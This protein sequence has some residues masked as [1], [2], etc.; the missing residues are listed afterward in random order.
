MGVYYICMS[1]LCAC[2]SVYYVF[3]W[4]TQRPEEGAR[5]SLPR[6]TDVSCRVGSG[7]GIQVI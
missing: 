1:V 5:F 7:D 2:V 3:A 6:V 4:C